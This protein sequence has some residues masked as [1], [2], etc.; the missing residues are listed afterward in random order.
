MKIKP[1]FILGSFNTFGDRYNSM[2]RHVNLGLILD[3]ATGPV[4]IKRKDTNDGIRVT[5]KTE[6]EKPEW[7]KY[8]ALLYDLET[9]EQITRN[10]LTGNDFSTTIEYTNAQLAGHK[11]YAVLLVYPETDLSI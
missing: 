7:T 10:P 2:S 1:G 5:L 6:N 9:K 3:S 4:S 11:S 8:E